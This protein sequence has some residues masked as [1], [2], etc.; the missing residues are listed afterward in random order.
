[1]DHNIVSEGPVAAFGAY[2]E[3]HLFSFKGREAGDKLSYCQLLRRNINL[4]YSSY[5]CL[6]VD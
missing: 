6:K 3:E 2:C 5:A 4:Q 1:V